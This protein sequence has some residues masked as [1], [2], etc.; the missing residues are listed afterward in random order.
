MKSAAV[1]YWVT[2]LVLCAGFYGVLKGWQYF[3]TAGAAEKDERAAAKAHSAPT[4]ADLNKTVQPFELTDQTGEP[5]KSDTLDGKVWVASF[6]FTNCPGTCWRLNQALSSL[7]GELDDEVRLISITCDPKNDTPEALAKYA[8]HFKAEPERWT[9][10]TGDFK[11]IQK[12]GQQSFLVAVQEGVHS[13][14]A[15]VVDRTG[16]VRGSFNMLDQDQIAKLKKTVG[17]LLAKTAPG[18]S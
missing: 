13:E 16:K 15:M 12:I 17:E 2:M 6:F 11:A 9:F 14:R 5:F 7:Q 10:L 4:I 18:K 1:R 8:K 3:Q